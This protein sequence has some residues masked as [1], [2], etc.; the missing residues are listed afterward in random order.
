MKKDVIKEEPSIVN[1][2][3]FSKGLTKASKSNSFS[4]DCVLMNIP[5]SS[6]NMGYKKSII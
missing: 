4:S 5:P 6:R 1:Q 2:V 3:S